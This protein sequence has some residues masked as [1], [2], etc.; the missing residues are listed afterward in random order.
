MRRKETD[1]IQGKKLK[2]EP[3][4]TRPAVKAQLKMNNEPTA[5]D[6]R[7]RERKE[8]VN[9]LKKSAAGFVGAIVAGQQ[10]GNYNNKKE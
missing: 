9:F 10:L 2:A 6:M 7:I 8:Y 3:A 4:A 5:A 1:P